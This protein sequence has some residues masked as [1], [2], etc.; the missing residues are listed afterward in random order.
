MRKWSF[1]PSE[2]R[3]E[4]EEEVA[5]LTGKASAVLRYLLQNQGA[6]V[7]RDEILKAIWQDVHV[8]PDLVREYIFDIRQ[9][10]GDDASN[11]RYI[12]TIRGK[13]FRLIG[14]VEVL[15]STTDPLGG[16]RRPRIAVLRPDCLEGGARW[17]RFADGMADE[18]ITDLARFSDLA[19]IARI[20]SFAADTSKSILDVVDQLNADYVVES[21]LSAW[22]DQLKAQFQLIDGR[23]G[24]HVWAETIERP[25]TLMPQLSGDIAL[26]VANHIGGPSG[27]IVRAEQRYAVRRPLS[28]LNAYEHY[29]MACHL[30]EHYDQASMQRGLAHAEKVIELD[31]EFARGH[32]MR[33]MFCDRGE[34]VSNARSHEEWVQETALSAEKALSID[35]RDPLILSEC[36]RAFANTGRPALARNA[37]VRAADFAQNDS[38][39]ALNT[40]SSLTLVVGEFDLA[41]QMLDTAFSLCPL[42]AAFYAFAR[43]R[44]LLFSGRYAEAEAVAETGP[45]YESTYVIRLLSQ[46]LQNKTDAARETLQVLRAKYPH[47]DFDA[48]P[49]NMGMVAEPTLE[50]YHEAVARLGLD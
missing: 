48:Y 18:L 5:H 45:D 34:A 17:Q 42:P 43:G 35:S 47:F 49:K 46:A 25:V 41:E 9:A 38:L 21:S 7:S 50:V 44:N 28:E 2:N 39:A 14:G 15:R 31:P 23:N 24:L 1:I 19:V 6:V 12:E 8:T 37:A 26:T 27:A 30:E 36:A 13:G 3:L 4:A 40:A 10:L 20:S 11:P 33:S 32:L 22:P 16:I 29:V